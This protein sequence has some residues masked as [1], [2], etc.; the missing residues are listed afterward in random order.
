MKRCIG[1][2]RGGSPNTGA[3]V[4]VELRCVTILACGCIYSPTQKLIRSH[5]STI[6][7]E[8]NP[9]LPFSF[10]EISEKG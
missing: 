5:C 9:Q 1:P 8:F 10:P 6:F 7:V 3:S 4:P 2:S